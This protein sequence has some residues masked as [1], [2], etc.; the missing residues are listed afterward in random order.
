MSSLG[1]HKIWPWFIRDKSGQDNALKRIGTK[2]S[3]STHFHQMNFPVNGKGSH[4]DKKEKP[5]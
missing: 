5:F 2:S 1:H 4:W 3:P